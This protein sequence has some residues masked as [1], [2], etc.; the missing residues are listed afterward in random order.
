[1]I[2]IDF[3]V[4][5]LN[6]DYGAPIEVA[7]SIGDPLY[8]AKN[9]DA[10]KAGIGVDVVGTEEENNIKG[11]NHNDF[12]SGSGGSDIIN[13]YSGNDLVEYGSLAKVIDGGDDVD[14]LIVFG[15]E[16]LLIDLRK[17]DVL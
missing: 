17:L 14:T 13:A 3:N 4:D 6:T 12:I 8:K 7:T 16:K 15:K 1:M 9:I 5:V 2:F 10:R 11:S